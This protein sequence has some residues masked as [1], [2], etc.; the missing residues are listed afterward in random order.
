MIIIDAGH[1]ADTEKKESKPLS[2]GYVFKEYEFNKIVSKFLL[3][4]L[5][6]KNIQ[7]V[8]INEHTDIDMPLHKRCLAANEIYKKNK[9]SIFISIHSN[10]FNLKGTN[11][12]DW[13]RVNGIETHYYH[14][15]TKGRN[16][17]RI[18]QYH[19]VKDLDLKDRGVKESKFTVLKY[20]KMP[21]VLPE[22]GFYTNKKWVKQVVKNQ[23]ID[24]SVCDNIAL[25]LSNGIQEIMS[26]I[27]LVF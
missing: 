15:S 3:Y 22:I 23:M 26:N 19:M 27:M 13:N 14:N 20:T 9:N 24:N 4:H 6:A 1:G 25:T 17:A 11:P 12:P 7:C 16:I 10:Q 8:L 21:A 5:R 18:L 2:C